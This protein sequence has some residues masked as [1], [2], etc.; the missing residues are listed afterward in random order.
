MRAISRRPSAF[1]LIELLVVIAIIAVLAGLLFP[2]LGKIQENAN[3]TKCTSNLRQIGVAIN[4]YTVD[5]DGL[6]P[7]PLSISQF[8]TL[9]GGPLDDASLYKKLAKYLGYSDQVT[10]TTPREGANI[11]VC[12]SWQRVTK[13]VVAPVYVLNPR[14]ITELAK[15]PFGDVNSHLEPV[16]KSTLSTWIDATDPAN[17]R[18]VDLS[19][20]WALKDAD[21]LAFAGIPIAVQPDGFTSMPLKPVHGDIRNALFYDW[22]VGKLSAEIATNDA[23]K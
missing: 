5:N 11:F 15:S 19:R 7:G 14:Q 3:S 12:P 2:V 1:T 22:H 8:S 23:P 20:T 17:E 21:Q 13:N 16:K 4:A 6:L 10:P 18:P 9:T